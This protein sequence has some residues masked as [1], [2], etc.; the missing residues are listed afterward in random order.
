M[1]SERMLRYYV[2]LQF[3]LWN[4]F[5]VCTSPPAP[6]ALSSRHPY[7][8]PRAMSLEIGVHLYQGP[9]Q[10]ILAFA[11]IPHNHSFQPVNEESPLL[12]SREVPPT[13]D[14][15]AQMGMIWTLGQKK[16]NDAGRE[17]LI[18]YISLSLNKQTDY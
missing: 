11:V 5:T 9:T 1:Q 4:S 3:Q 2:E 13:F 16:T 8:S 12:Y 18:R 7:S 14:G 15:T 10:S 6:E 17:A